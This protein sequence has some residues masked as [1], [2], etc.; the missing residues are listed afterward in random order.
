MKR[1][2]LKRSGG[3]SGKTGG[4][5]KTKG[6]LSRSLQPGQQAQLFSLRP[7]P[8]PPS[9]PPFQSLQ[10]S[11]SAPLEPHRHTMP[12]H[13]FDAPD[14]NLDFILS[15]DFFCTPDYITP[16]NQNLLN[17]VNFN[18]ENTPCP[19]SPEKVKTASKTS[20]RGTD[21]ISLNPLS[22]SLSGCPHI[23]ELEEDTL[24]RDEAKTEKT[25]VKGNKKVH[26]YV[27]QS[28]VA[29]RC[30]VMP[31]PCIKNPYLNEGSDIEI[32]PFGNRRSKCAGFFPAIIGGDG[33]SRYHTDFHEIEQIGTGNF[34]RVFKVLKRIDG[35]LYAV[36]HSTRQLHHDTERRKALMEVQA[37]A[38]LGSHE[39]ITSYYSSWFENEQLY[40]QMEL[41]DYSL[42]VGKSS[43]SFTENEALK[44]LYQ[45]AKALQFIHDRGI[46]H[47]DVKPDNI[48]VKNSVYK[49]GDFGCATPLDKS[50]P[51]EEGDARYMPLEILNDVYDHLSKVD[52]FS[53]GAAIYELVRGSPLPDSGPQ[54][55][56]LREGRLSLLP[57]H[58]LQFQNLLKM[59][60]DPDPRQRPSAKDLVQNPI[61]DRVRRNANT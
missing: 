42:S 18:K 60:V 19:K 26:S 4:R 16:D 31:P 21:S 1:K 3:G 22:P 11:D 40:I 23:E 48:Y 5:K 25:S 28:A 43:Q 52:I 53:L 17:S 24:E 32:D 54:F 27:P 10:D 50:L 58:S 45:I 7:Q 20:G 13:D 2:N 8:P 59:M 12:A 39:N 15:Q 6:P 56:N 30:R 51:I 37:L 38:A 47:L 33:L 46:A 57:G 61:F 41:C 34:S 29:L 35:C 49:L 44:A 55:L 36:K 14:A 9:F